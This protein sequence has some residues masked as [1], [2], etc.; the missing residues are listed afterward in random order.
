MGIPTRQTH[1][2]VSTPVGS[3]YGCG[4]VP[5]SDRLS[6]LAIH[7][8]VGLPHHTDATGVNHPGH[9]VTTPGAYRRGVASL[10][11]LPD[12]TRLPLM[13]LD[14]A[15][16]AVDD[17]VA[18]ARRQMAVAVRRMVAGD[19]Q[20]RDISLPLKGDPGLFGPDSVTWRVHSDSS[21]FVG[22]LRALLLQTMHPR[23]MAGVADHSAYRNDPLGRLTRTAEY[24]GVT[25]FGTTEEA[26]EMVAMV[27]RVHTYVVGTTP[28]GLPYEANDPHLML[29]V[30]HALVDSFLSTFQ[31]YGASPLS[32]SDADRYVAEMAVVADRLGCDP[33]ATS[34][35]GLRDYFRH[36]RPEL[37]AG[38]QARDAARWLLMP[39]LP[40]AVR[41]TYAVITGAAI[42]LLPRWVRRQ[43][44]L[45]LA[46]GVDPVLV[47]PST[48]VLLRTLDWV[49]AGHPAPE[50]ATAS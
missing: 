40:L 44:W 14:I 7:L 33:A 27:R 3:T 42:G 39:P 22:G 28:E 21:M 12:F 50:Q 19:R 36:M 16:G 11:R 26:D 15:T 4:T 30:H 45:P 49:M 41:P 46:P 9:V 29:W 43:L 24:V 32:P 25:T 18:G 48:T 47:R 37:G 23:V 6:P 10:P 1:S 31:R 20:V 8:L 34:T 2:G 13:G 38:T 17:A 35:A 5:E